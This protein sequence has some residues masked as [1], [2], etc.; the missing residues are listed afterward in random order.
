[1]AALLRFMKDKQGK[2]KKVS[3]ISKKTLYGGNYLM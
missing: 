3:L 1:M 2:N